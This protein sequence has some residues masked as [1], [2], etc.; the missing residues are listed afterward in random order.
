MAVDRGEG[1]QY[2]WESSHSYPIEL[3][4]CQSQDGDPNNYN[5]CHETFETVEDKD[6]HR[7]NT[8][9][10]WWPENIRGMLYDDGRSVWYQS[11][12]E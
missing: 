2:C 3:P 7:A 5:G 1:C 12:K 8:G 4:H 9:G 11:P 6:L 10:C